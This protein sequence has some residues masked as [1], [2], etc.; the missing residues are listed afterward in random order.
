M[1]ARRSTAAFK[2]AGS[3]QQPPRQP[4]PA[5]AP[6]AI[7]PRT[8]ARPGAPRYTRDQRDAILR[9]VMVQGISIADARRRAIAGEL[10]VPAF[11]IPYASACDIV[12]HDRDSYTL[13]NPDV[14]R[15][16]IDRE[17]LAMA[18]AARKVA[19][20][21]RTQPDPN[22]DE[23]KRAVQALAAARA[24]IQ[25]APKPAP[26]PAGKTAQDTTPTPPSVLTRLGIDHSPT[27]T[28][29]TT[30]GDNEPVARSARV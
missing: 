4:Q 5:S 15:S 18:G 24:A 21:L 13:R 17:I 23:I 27:T 12:R 25:T 1:P 20:K 10:D 19:A 28:P 26:R 3:R 30:T 2:R 11:R 9:A 29:T 7:I 6:P 8:M 22:P 16:E 14:M